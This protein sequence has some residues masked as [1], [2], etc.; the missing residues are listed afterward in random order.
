[1][2][3]LKSFCVG[4]I[5]LLATSLPAFAQARAG[6]SPLDAA[7]GAVT[8]RCALW[9]RAGMDIPALYIKDGSDYKIFQLFEMMFQKE[10]KYRGPVPIAVYRK[11]TEA[12]IAQRKAEGMKKSEQEYIPL[13]AINPK[14]MKDIGVI[15][16]PGKLENKPEKEI[17]VFDWSEK[18]FP[19][20]TIRIANFSRRG[21]MGQLTPQGSDKGETF[22]LKH[23]AFFTSE[24]LAEKRKIYELQLAASVNKKPQ[25]IYSSAASFYGDARTMIFIIP[26]MTSKAGAEEA[27]KLDFRSIRDRKR[28]ATSENKNSDK[29]AQ[30]QERAAD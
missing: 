3:L 13:F 21:L 16:L 5:A 19:Y 6:A 14:G 15:L 24:K 4:V 12:E 18:A 2:H 20:G 26:D 11:A 25:V 30:K 9:Q 28:V 10:Y 7:A 27:P 1:M 8:L 23:G 22:K 17:L 29:S